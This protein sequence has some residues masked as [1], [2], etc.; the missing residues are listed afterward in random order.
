MTEITIGLIEKTDRQIV[1]M[2]AYENDKG[3][4]VHANSYI[5]KYKENGKV[6]E[7]FLNSLLPLLLV[8]VPEAA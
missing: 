3:I 5:N 2:L 8:P 4:K 1:W 7:S 6:Y